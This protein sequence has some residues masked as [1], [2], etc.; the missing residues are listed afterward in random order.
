MKLNE[1]KALIRSTT[2][3]LIKEEAEVDEM[4]RIA[5]LIKL[6]DSEKVEEAKKKFKDTWIIKI[7]NHLEQNPE[8]ATKMELATASGKTKQQDVNPVINKLLA[9]EILTMGDLVSPKKEKPANSGV[10]GRPLTNA[11]ERKGED[12]IKA[13]IK[14]VK[15]D[16]TPRQEYIDWFV[17][18]HSQEDYDK[19][20]EFVDNYMSRKLDTP[21]EEKDKLLDNINTFLAGLG[22]NVKKR[23]RPMATGDEDE[24]SET[25]KVDGADSKK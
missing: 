22:Y 13:I 12:V 23:G 3:K 6:G 8:G 14:K 16:E 20:V 10:R 17:E 5:S 15:A 25:E 1:F 2:A 7:F 4:A 19:L 18:N 24:S 21:K 11:D 9:A